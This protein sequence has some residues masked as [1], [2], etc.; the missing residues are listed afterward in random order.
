M[1]TTPIEALLVVVVAAV[2]SA[3][4]AAA[5]GSTP[6][7]DVPPWHW[8]S[9]AV[10]VDQGAG[11]LVGYPAA[12]VE[13]AQ[14]TIAQ[15]YDGFAHSGARGAQAWVERFTYNRPASWPAP[16]QRSEIAQFTLNGMRLSVRDDTA[17]AVFVAAVTTRQGRAV[18]TPMRV[19]LRFDGQ[20]WQVDYAGLASESS[21][22]P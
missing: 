12:P 11:L 18:T 17:T 20:D 2:V 1:R 3:G 15:V 22:F 5:A 8:A 13:L 14:N 4:P 6:F 21:F 7:P 10:I 19:E 16:L 9:D